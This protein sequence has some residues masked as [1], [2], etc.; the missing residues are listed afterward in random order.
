VAAVAAWV[1][2][3][4]FLLVR[5]LLTAQQIDR[6]ADFTTSQLRP[7]NDDTELIA[8]AERTDDI[9]ADI[10][11]QTQPLSRQ[12]ERIEDT[13]SSIDQDA[14]SIL[15]TSRSIERR[16]SGILAAAERVLAQARSIQQRTEAIEGSAGG[17]ADRFTA[18]LRVAE[19]IAC[20]EK[21]AVGQGHDPRDDL[22]AS[23]GPAG[24]T[25]CPAST[26][27]SMPS[28]CSSA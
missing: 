20:G 21:L 4:V 22:H 11:R 27:A 10:A 7:I 13:T 25:G 15:S 14:E 3:A 18:I 8:P 5:L 1:I 16:T 23:G 2:V 24:T 17:I 9:A 19:T 26:G 6:R 12:L 28:S